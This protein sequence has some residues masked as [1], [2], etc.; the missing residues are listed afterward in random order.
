MKLEDVLWTTVLWV[1]VIFFAFAAGVRAGEWEKE[2][3]EPVKYTLVI[4][5]AEPVMAE[6]V[7]PTTET[8]QEPQLDLCEDTYL[9][10]DIP[11]SYELQAML[12]GACLEADVDFELALAVIEQETNFRNVKGD[13]GR[14][15]GFF[16]IWPT[17]HADRMAELGVTNL[18]D[19]ESNFRVGCNFLGEC[20]EKYGL[21]KGLGYY[22]SGKAQVT[23]YSRSV[24]EKMEKYYG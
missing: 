2:A 9:R 22:N 24:M 14:A 11:M 6:V 3:E 12:Y 8:A 19:P 13:S 15:Y 20:I 21:E 10:D 7:V 1:C 23:S 18:M 4:S 17:W 5:E 16:Q